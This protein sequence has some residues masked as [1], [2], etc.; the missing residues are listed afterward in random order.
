MFYFAKRL[1]L[2]TLILL[3][4]FSIVAFGQTSVFI[5]EVHYDNSGTDTGESIE[6]A[7][8]AGTDLTGWSVVLYNGS[9][10]SRSTYNTQNLTG[11]IPNTANGFGFV[12]I[13][14]PSNGIQNGSPDGIA[15]VN[16]NGQVIQFLSYE[17]SFTAANG[18][19]SGLTSTDI[20]VAESSSTA[21]GFS[22][23]LTG[24]GTTYEEFTWATPAVNTFGAANNDQVFGTP[25]VN[26]LINEFVANH[27]GSDTNEF[28]ELL[29]SAN[30]D[31]SAYSLLVIEGDGT[32]AGT[33]DR[34]YTIGTTD[35]NG[36]WTTGLM[37]NQIEN[38]SNTFLLVENF[39]GAVGNDLDTDNNGTLDSTPWDKIIDGVA[40][41]DG[42]PTDQT[43]SDVNLARG[44][45][46]LTFT[47][48]GASRVPNGT[49][50]GSTNDWVR[51]DFDGTGLPAFPAATADEGEAINTPGVEN[52][53]QGS[54]SQ[55]VN[56]VINEV[57]ADNP[58]TDANEFIELYDGGVGNT[59][60]NGLVIVLFNGS[61]DLSYNTI[62]LTGFSTNAQ[63]YFVIGSASVPN[64]DL[65]AFTTN[66][67][68]NG[69]DA[70][71]LY[72]APASSFPS[73]SAVT[74][75]N[76]VDALVYDTNDSDDTGLLA[77]LNAGQG[78]INEAQ[79]GDATA[80]SI[81]RLPNGQ[82]GALN[83]D[84]YSV[85]EPTPGAEN[86]G[87]VTPPNP[88]KIT[89]AEARASAQG[90]Q[91][92]IEGVLT[93]V[94]EF[95]GPAFI[96]DNTGGIAIF[97]TD[98]HAASFQIGDQLIITAT[99][100][101]FNDQ[102]QLGSIEP[103]NITKV[104]TPTIT[105][106][107]KVITL[108]Q[109]AQYEGQLVKIASVSFPK[110]GDLLFGNSNYA[111]TDASGSGQVRIDA[112]VASLITKT[113]PQSCEVIG[114][115]GSFRGT[116]QLLPRFAAD[117]PCATEFVPGNGGTGTD[118][119]LEVVTWNI[120]WFGNAGNGPSDLN[121][122]KERAKAIIQ[123]LNA[124]VYAFQE[125]ANESLM[126]TL[127]NEL[128]DYE[129][130]IQLN[131][132]SRPPNVPGESQKV[133][134][135]YKKSTVSVVETRTLLADI[136]PLYNGGDASKLVGY[137]DSDPTRFY[138][139]GRLPFMMIADVTIQ[140]TTERFH[141]VNIHARANSSNDPQGRYA[142]RKYDVEK[143]KELLD[144]N[145]AQ[146]NIVLAGDYNDD[147]DETVANISST[148]SSYEQYANDNAPTPGDDQFYKILTKPLSLQGFRSFVFSD[149]MIDH[150]SVSDELI[151]NYVANTETVHYEVYT[152]AYANTVS[153]HLPVS[154]VLKLNKVLPL[155]VTTNC[156]DNPA[157]TRNWVINNPNSVAV[158]VNWTLA[159]QT[160]VLTAQP[161][162]NPLTTQTDSVNVLTVTW[163]N[164]QGRAVS[165]SAN[166]S[167][168]ACVSVV[169]YTLIDAWRNRA[170][171][172]IK[173]GDVINLYDLPSR[174]LTV[175]A[176]MSDGTVGSVKFEMEFCGKTLKRIENRAPFTL[177]GDFWGNYFGHYLF[178]GKY[179]LKA[180]PFTEDKGKGFQGESSTINFEIIKK[181]ELKLQIRKVFPN[182]TRGLV[183]VK[184]AS[185]TP[186]K[187][188]IYNQKGELVR[189]K[190]VT[191]EQTL[192]FNLRGCGRGLFTVKLV[193][194]N[195]E[196]VHRR[197]YVR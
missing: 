173:E 193:D 196:Q 39:T 131:A 67:L 88:T 164:E 92:T 9:S 194:Q 135:L 2:L 161:G 140:G 95:G 149:N 146:A 97:D 64:V 145:Y 101:S 106:T 110:P 168:A 163:N 116:P 94:G 137:P 111:V 26:L 108:A 15:L 11:A 87:V 84:A 85:A 14:Y 42:G 86:G 167:E 160:G 148:V 21:V 18:P 10:S 80:V 57:D 177:F 71:A 188:M 197:L 120:E 123:Q 166:A 114:V 13:T 19:A 24:T 118:S 192:Y 81:Q 117:L 96:Q 152:A 79:N 104:T 183:F 162:D 103:A 157:L 150:I 109:L 134:F 122:Q 93:A 153:D 17:G 129:L 102:L 36:Y 156:S 32:G 132:V 195:G 76:L 133:A 169:S 98:V 62:D 43:Y 165:V 46:G 12:S 3:C 69:A 23:Q 30:T 63:G 35:A 112:D 60:L 1:H 181:R 38:G 68:Q 107:P 51:N 190:D 50:T 185:P 182:P 55:P 52:K 61:N 113:Q 41:N 175:Q 65:T 49:N 180:T 48:G 7:G 151:D 119:T 186:A 8:P 147:V 47:V 4:S 121:L 20:G 44:Y 105:I 6:I 31:F 22:L 187:L 141:F 83:T 189:S 127:A 172:E 136:H 144:A 171:G 5:N 72:Q 56:V 73:G 174:I 100:T 128:T 53:T 34:V 138:A 124:D 78:Q 75:D 159:G 178:P 90:T 25:A 37:N 45:D 27:T 184:L 130:V 139:S 74:T 99:L 142:M 77:L 179:T 170:I 143:L 176:N 29:G 40:V 59:S 115:I 91:V 54:V 158:A 191:G 28:I 155:T 126:Q 33:I 58:G 66:G 70:V 154:V 89:I 16:N 82:G 125:I